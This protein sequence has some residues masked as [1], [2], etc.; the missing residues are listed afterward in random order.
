MPCRN[1]AAGPNHIVKP[2]LPKQEGAGG[3]ALSWLPPFN[4]LQAC[5]LRRAPFRLK[6]PG[7]Y[8]QR[9]EAGGQTHTFWGAV[10]P[11]HFLPS[12][13]PSDVDS[14]RS[15]RAYVRPT[16]FFWPGPLLYEVARPHAQPHTTRRRSRGQSEGLWEIQPPAST[17]CPGMPL[18]TRR[19][20]GSGRR[21]GP[22]ACRV[23]WV[24]SC[25]GW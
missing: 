2:P 6:D 5:T 13:I 4:L 12:C 24:G 17:L 16:G 20:A 3:R 10:Q 25:A 8:Q 19:A 23:S 15:A 9:A 7:P 18:P 11:F 21:G 22:E 1:P 14:T